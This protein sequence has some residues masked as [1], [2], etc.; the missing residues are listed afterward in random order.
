MCEFFEPPRH[1]D[2]KVF[3]EKILGVFAPWR[4]TLPRNRL[5]YSILC[6]NHRASVFK[7]P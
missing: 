3:N 6:R 7:H 1:K 5:D 2:A 4:F